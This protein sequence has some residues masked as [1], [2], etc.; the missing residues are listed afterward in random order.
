MK[1]NGLI[2]LSAVLLLLGSF[3][4]AAEESAPL[5]NAQDI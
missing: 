4:G 2:L 5:Y 1:N 3:N